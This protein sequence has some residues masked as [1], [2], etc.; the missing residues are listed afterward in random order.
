MASKGKKNPC[1]PPAFGQS[2]LSTISSNQKIV[3][4]TES[5]VKV[6]KKSK[7]K[8]SKPFSKAIMESAKTRAKSD[9]M[10]VGL[11]DVSKETNKKIRKYYKSANVDLAEEDS[12]DDSSELARA[13]LSKEEKRNNTEDSDSDEYE[14]QEILEKRELE[15]RLEFL[16]KWRGWDDIDDRTWEPVDNLDGAEKLIVAYE[17]LQQMDESVEPRKETNKKVTIVMEDDY[18]AEEILD[19]RGAGKKAEYLVRWK[20]FEKVEDQTWESLKDLV[21]YTDIIEAFEKKIEENDEKTTSIDETHE[22]STSNK[23]KIDLSVPDSDS[24]ELTKKQKLIEQESDKEDVSGLPTVE[25][26]TNT[27][28]VYPDTPKHISQDTSKEPKESDPDSSNSSP[29]G[30]VTPTNRASDDGEIIRASAQK[31]IGITNTSEN[32]E[33]LPVRTSNNDS[34]EIIIDSDKKDNN[35]SNGTVD[36][37]NQPTKIKDN[38]SEAFDSLFSGH[39]G[40]IEKNEETT[41]TISEKNSEDLGSVPVEDKDQPDL[42]KMSKNLDNDS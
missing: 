21:D 10:Q 17:K 12:D 38:A 18:E 35:I 1:T 9:K 4:K 37:V 32:K 14:V 2:V 3:D 6:K 16:V 24:D 29:G 11:T 8:S 34:G 13:I 19:K 40:S 39:L 31:E 26:D 30:T 5:A 41:K 25:I 22:S 20:A 23:R 33:D 15:E 42:C 36:D 7:N 28:R 27:E